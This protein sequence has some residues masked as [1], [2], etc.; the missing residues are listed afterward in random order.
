[1]IS[2]QNAEFIRAVSAVGISKSLGQSSQVCI[3]MF[4]CCDL[5]QNRLDD[6]GVRE[7]VVLSVPQC[8]L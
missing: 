1:M 3:S 8:F 5:L 7:V 6:R 2:S 4:N